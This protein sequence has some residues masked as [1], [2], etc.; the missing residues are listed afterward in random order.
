MTSLE[1]LDVTVSFVGSGVVSRPTLQ[2]A[3]TPLCDSSAR[4]PS[5][6]NGWPLTVV[7]RVLLHPLFLGLVL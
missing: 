3:I 2:K 6:H 7:K 4:L 1:Y 5:V